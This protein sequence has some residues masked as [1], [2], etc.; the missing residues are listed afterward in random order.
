MRAPNLRNPAFLEGIVL[1]LAVAGVALVA[2]G[3]IRRRRRRA[4]VPE[5]SFL[6]GVRPVPRANLDAR[7]QEEANAKASMLESESPDIFQ[8]HERW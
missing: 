1:G 8:T 5:I 4:A 2:T 7:P 3:A 6:D